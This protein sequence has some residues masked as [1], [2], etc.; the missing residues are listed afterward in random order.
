MTHIDPNYLKNYY[1][2]NK[3]KIF[4]YQ[5]SYY[6][7]N[8]K[9]L[10][11]QDIAARLAESIEQRQHR[12]TK[13]KVWAD[14][15]RHLIKNYDLQHKYGITLAEYNSLRKKQNLKC[16][17]CFNKTK[18]VVDHDHNTGKVRGLLCNFCN[19]ALSLYDNTTR[20]SRLLKYL[21]KSN[22]KP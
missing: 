11:K 5:R 9:R 20:F 17:I 3:D 15:N 19:M 10:L 6:Q 14:K 22:E 13:K 7:L 21:G 1:I 18:L 8:R 2:K 4:A 16:A 12:L